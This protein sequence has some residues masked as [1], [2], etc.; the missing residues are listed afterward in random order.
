M[1]QL[2]DP[3]KE[4]CRAGG[5]ADGDGEQGGE[6]RRD[7]LTVGG[8]RSGGERHV[9]RRTSRAGWREVQPYIMRELRMID[10]L[11]FTF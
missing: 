4:W 6:E 5:G 1:Q 7:D 9:G 3:A 11:W 10:A 8:G 2:Q